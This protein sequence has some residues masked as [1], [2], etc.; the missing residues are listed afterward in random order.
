VG[1]L[2]VDLVVALVAGGL[3]VATLLLVP[4]QV[5]GESLVAIGNLQS[6]AFF[7]VFTGTVML[8]AAGGLAAQALLAARAGH[9]PRVRFPRAPFVLTV[10]AVFVAFAVGCHVIGLLPSAVL[11]ILVLGRL[12]EF[13]DWRILIPVAVLV[14][15]AVY[16]LFEK[17]LL[18]ILPRGVAFGS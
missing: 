8:A 13:R 15:L 18:V 12:W 4:Y 1:R 2:N 3:A 11:V 17:A 16:L 6:P 9:G 5:P 14:P 10:A 7:P